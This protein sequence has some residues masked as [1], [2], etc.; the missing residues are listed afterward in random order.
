MTMVEPAAA[1]RR[2]R[3]GFQVWGQ[4]V[5]WDELMAM[6]QRIDALGFDSLWSNDHLLP[7]AGGGPV[8][9]E[10]ERGPVW[11]GWMTLAGWAE[12]TERVTLGC[13]VSSARL[14]ANPALLVRMATALDHAS[15]RPGHP[16]PRGGL[17]R[18]RA[19]GLRLPVPEPARASRPP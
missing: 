5:G 19:S 3:I 7:V 11:D 16:R 6:G 15:R 14:S 8:A 2:L 13:L 18:R 4:F 9:L 12:R 17:A 10:L 1:S